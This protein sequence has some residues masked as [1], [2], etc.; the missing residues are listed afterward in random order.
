VSSVATRGLH[1]PR[2]TLDEEATALARDLVDFLCLGGMRF[3]G[4]DVL[5]CRLREA[6]STNERAA[7]FIGA[8]WTCCGAWASGGEE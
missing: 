5:I 2:P 3:T 8:L 4:H 1:P 7:A 6:C